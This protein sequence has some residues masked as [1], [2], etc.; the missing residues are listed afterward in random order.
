MKD[1]YSHDLVRHNSGGE[2]SSRQ[3]PNEEF[4]IDNIIR[5]DLRRKFTSTKSTVKI[6]IV[7]NKKY[8]DVVSVLFV[9]KYQSKSKIPI[10]IVSLL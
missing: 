10:G 7:S 2:S 8:V 9:Q 4:E 6:F 5:N 1:V 3:Q